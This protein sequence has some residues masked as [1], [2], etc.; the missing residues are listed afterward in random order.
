MSRGRAV[1][2]AEDRG[3]NCPQALPLPHGH[4]P[5]PAADIEK[6]WFHP[7][8]R[9]LRQN[10]ALFSAQI[11]TLVNV[12]HLPKQRWRMLTPSLDPARVGFGHRVSV[13]VTF[14]A[15]S[16]TERSCYCR[17]DK[18]VEYPQ[19]PNA[20]LVSW[21]V[22]VA[23]YSVRK[24]HPSV[25]LASGD[26]RD[27]PFRSYKSDCLRVGKGARWAAAITMGLRREFQ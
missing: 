9:E 24:T 6:S 10:M 15:G 17:P 26:F 7:A 2:A 16:L 12:A 21:T 19:S 5:G 8:P 23:S 14:K 25:W 1:A 4:I 3:S 11:L 20:D 27:F 22:R 13:N 18:S